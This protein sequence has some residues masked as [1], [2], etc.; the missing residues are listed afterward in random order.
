MDRSHVGFLPA[1]M[2]GTLLLFYLVW[3]AMHDIAHGDKG[4]LEWTVLAICAL[5]FAGLYRQALR[6]LRSKAKVA[7]LIGTGLLFSLF[8]A[9]AAAAMLRPK[10][11]KDPMLATTFLTIGLPVLGL[12]GYHLVREAQQTRAR[13]G[14][15]S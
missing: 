6:H 14:S 15:E 9:G 5:A 1:M 4:T 8:S 3:A 12:I 11:D 2:S 10:Y 7:W 13:R